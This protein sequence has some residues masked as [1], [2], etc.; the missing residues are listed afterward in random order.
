MDNVFMGL[1]RIFLTAVVCIMVG[2]HSVDVPLLPN[3][4]E[5][6]SR[7]G[8]NIQRTMDLLASSTPDNRNSVKILFYGQSIIGGQWH[9]FF[10]RGVGERFPYADLTVEN[11]AIGGYSSKYLVK[12]VEHDVLMSHPDLVVFHVYGD[13]I[14]YEE[15]IHTIR[16]RTAA[17]V[18]IMTDHWKRK[19]WQEGQ[20]ELNSWDSFFDRFLPLVAKKYA[21]EIVDV[22]WPWKMVLEKNNWKPDELLRDKAHL[23]DKGN[24][25]MAQLALRQMLY[26]PELESTCCKELVYTLSVAT[27]RTP[28]DLQWD[29]N[30]LEFEFAGSRVDLLRKHAGGASCTI[31]ID[32]HPPSSDSDLT[33]HT[34]TTSIAKPYEWPE[35]MKIGFEKIPELQIW[36]LTIESIDDVGLKAI[37][38]QLKG[39]KTGFDGRGTNTEDFTSNSGQV[40]IKAGDWALKRKEEAFNSGVIQ[41]GMKIRWE[42]VRL[43]D[44]IYFPSGILERDRIVS[45]TLVNGL[46]N[47]THTIKLVADGV[48]PPITGVRIYRPLL[49]DETFK[50]IGVTPESEFNIEEISAPTPLD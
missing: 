24:R 33:R 8:V 15:I 34:R 9:A 12:T 39:D 29:G 50:E 36:T 3:A 28:G 13:H 23:N 49:A 18:M 19:D 45:Q 10:E 46:R 26:R 27:E 6:R 38:F 21:C 4:S 11:R 35:I 25:L 1:K 2:C 7:W 5:D 31:T 37:S 41:P 43:G 17:E 16:R 48:P 30:K 40:T 47:T 14:R 42:T 44:D 20:L 22:R 32:G